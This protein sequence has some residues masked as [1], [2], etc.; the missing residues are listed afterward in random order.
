[1]EVVAQVLEDC[2]FP[3]S[4][5]LESNAS[6]NKKRFVKVNIQTKLKVVIYQT[7]L[8]DIVKMSITFIGASNLAVIRSLA[9]DILKMPSLVDS[10]YIHVGEDD[11]DTRL[12]FMLR[13]VSEYQLSVLLNILS[14]FP[15]NISTTN[16]VL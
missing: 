4:E 10:P 12:E 1:M 2:H 3:Y 8:G 16:E 15:H 14:N 7:Y 6:N 13:V 11:V 5:V 9:S